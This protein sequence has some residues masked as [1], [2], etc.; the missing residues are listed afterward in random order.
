LKELLFLSGEGEVS[1]TIGTLNRFVL[2]THWMTS[3]LKILARV[4]VIQYLI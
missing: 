1:P 2:K 3:F 4:W